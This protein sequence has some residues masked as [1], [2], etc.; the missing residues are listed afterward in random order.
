MMGPI[1]PGIAPLRS[2]GS[3]IDEDENEDVKEV[4]ILN[5]NRLRNESDS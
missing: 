5:L 4:P 3:I 2:H 1:G